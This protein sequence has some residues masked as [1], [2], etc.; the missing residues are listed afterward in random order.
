MH[1]NWPL[2]RQHSAT[3]SVLQYGPCWCRGR[4]G[5]SG[6][7]DL[8]RHRTVEMDLGPLT[9]NVMI[10][11]ERVLNG[12]EAMC[13]ETYQ[14]LPDPKIVIAT[15]PCPSARTF[16]NEAPLAWMPVRDLLPVELS[17]DDCVSGRPESLLGAVLQLVAEESEA[18]DAAAQL[19]R[20]HA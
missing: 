10:V 11:S 6:T 1:T 19:R 3:V 8:F 16:W 4:P 9:S 17:L 20:A 12:A 14:S 5:D 2:K 15:A 13:R 18:D 7:F